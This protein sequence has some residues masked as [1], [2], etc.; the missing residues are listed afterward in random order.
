MIVPLEKYILSFNQIP[1]KINHLVLGAVVIMISGFLLS[2]CDDCITGNGKMITKQVKI[3]DITQL[4]L[5]GDANVILVNDS[6]DSLTIS[7]ESNIVDLYEFDE[8]GKSLKIKTASCIM[9]HETVTITIPLK[10]LESLTLNGSGNFTS[11]DMLKGTD[12]ELNL[13]GSGDVNLFVESE[14]ITGDINGSG[15]IKLKGSA[16]NERVK[17]NGSGDID[18]SEFAAGQVK[19]TV[20]GSGDCK[21]LATTALDVVIRGSGNVYYKGSPDINTEVK[22][23]GSVEKLK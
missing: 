4:R 21:V 9:S 6:T 5:M 15:N 12:I 19:V 20:N 2:S 17:I 14:N 11:R 18:A 22:G 10:T 16:K 3:G 7:G 8:S 1:M 13:N 23:S